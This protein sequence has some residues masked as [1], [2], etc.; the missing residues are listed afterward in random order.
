MSWNV[1]SFTMDDVSLCC[2][3]TPCLAVVFVNLRSTKTQSDKILWIHA[4]NKNPIQN[5]STSN[6][7]I[8][9]GTK[10]GSSLVNALRETNLLKHIPRDLTIFLIP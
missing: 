2:G 3:A 6:N 8:I 9:F 4:V 5:E 10:V 1:Q 7:L